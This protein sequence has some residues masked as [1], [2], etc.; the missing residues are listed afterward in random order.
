MSSSAA[1][2]AANRAN[3]QR[4]TGPVTPEGKAGSSR[5]GFRSQT[6]LLPGDD[7]AEYQ[8]L[9]DHLQSEFPPHDLTGERC[10]REMADAVGE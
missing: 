8:A 6:I 3:S 7:P 4:S 1:Q 10:L 5:H 2:L 9:L